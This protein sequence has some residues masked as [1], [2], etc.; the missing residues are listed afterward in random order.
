M[1]PSRYSICRERKKKNVDISYLESKAR[2]LGLC[3][4]PEVTRDPRQSSA[5]LTDELGQTLNFILIINPKQ[6]ICL[7]AFIIFNGAVCSAKKHENNY[8]KRHG[9][10][11]D[12]KRRNWK[13]NT[14][15]FRCTR[16]QRSKP[17][18]FVKALHKNDRKVESEKELKKSRQRYVLSSLF[19]RKCKYVCE[20]KVLLAKT[21]F[22]L[23]IGLYRKK[24][25]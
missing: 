24:F 9:E 18:S 22:R 13:G 12:P 7:E 17:P 23:L 21:L 1:C 15:V 19:E 20:T 5:V 2:N 4:F 16:K 6:R 3:W 14:R 10:I 25:L 11:A 8:C